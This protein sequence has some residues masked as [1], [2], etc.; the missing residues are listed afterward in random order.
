[1]KPDISGREDIERV[2][3]LFYEKIKT[4]PRIN[5]FFT[6]VV[7]INWEKHLPLM[8]DF[9]ENVLFYT[10][11]YEGN[12][13]VAHRALHARHPTSGE[14]FELWLQLFEETVDTYFEGI[15]ADKM[16]QHAGAIALVMQ[17]K[18]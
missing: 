6:R 10:G 18:I 17:Q 13:L 11:N 14:H 2:V 12:P 8:C 1:M 5:F 16:K 4:D 9:W 7:P 15:N 3:H